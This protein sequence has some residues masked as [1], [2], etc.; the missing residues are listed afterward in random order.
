VQGVTVG[1]VEGKKVIVLGTVDWLVAVNIIISETFGDIRLYTNQNFRTSFSICIKFVV[2]RDLF[3]LV[4]V[5]I[6]KLDVE[7]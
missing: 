5:D 2:H 7:M 4:I 6:A 3:S 1:R